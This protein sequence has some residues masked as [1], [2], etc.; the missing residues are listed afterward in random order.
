MIK[1]F[2]SFF[3]FAGALSNQSIPCKV[4]HEVVKELRGSVPASPTV[5]IVEEIA[6]RVCIKNY[7][8]YDEPVCR[9]AIKAM[10]PFIIRSTWRHYTDPHMLCSEIHLCKQEYQKKSL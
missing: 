8:E 1:A 5:E 7:K 4:C 2:I 6:L 3:L 9:G 10:T